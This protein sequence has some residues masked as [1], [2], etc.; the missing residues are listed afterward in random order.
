MP[1]L[2]TV[3]P[4]D[5][6]SRPLIPPVKPDMQIG[7]RELIRHNRSFRLLWFGQISSLLGDWLNLIASASLIALLTQSGLAVGSLFVIRM[8][9]PFLVSPIAGVVADRYSRKHILILTDVTRAITAFGFLLVREPSQIWL[10]YTL[11]AFQVSIAGFFIPARTA[12]LPEIVSARGLG[13]ANA[14]AAVT[15]SVMLATGSAIGGFISGAWG[16]Y[17]A[18]VIDGL[19][20][21]A[22]AAFIAQ[23]PSSRAASPDGSSQALGAALRQYLDGLLYLK[24][25]SGI[26]WIAVHKAAIALC[27]SGFQVV[28]VGI[29]REVFVMGVGGGISLGIL[30]A[31]TGIGSGIGPIAARYFTGDRGRPLR[32]GILCGYISAALGLAVASGLW[33]FGLVLSG[34]F[35]RGFGGSIVWVFSTQLLL[36]SV[37]NQIQGRVFAT[38]FA[39][40]ALMSAIGS[41]AAGA[42][43]D[44]S[45]S[46]SQVTWWMAWLTILPGGLWAACILRG[47]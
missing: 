25:N 40:F 15:W 29:A 37:P 19:S 22:S 46:L 33:S 43:L 35:L 17:P 24:Q 41:A 6:E 11:T 18:F 7:Y 47:R 16:V 13:A 26:F 30:F 31:I 3:G 20:F 12:I 32:F 34:T 38:E 21:L 44:A 14:L 27:V 9:A 8:M 1:S 36:Q 45:L 2:E 42:A 10:F 28:Q 23:I 39:A 4:S 5:R